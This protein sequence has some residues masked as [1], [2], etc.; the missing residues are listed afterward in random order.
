LTRPIR[1][2]S[3]A[4]TEWAKDKLYIGESKPYSLFERFAK[5]LASL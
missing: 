1:K 4:G 2:A 5:S 3:T